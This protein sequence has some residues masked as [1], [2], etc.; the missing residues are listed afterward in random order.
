MK[1]LHV[2]LV[3]ILTG[4]LAFANS[5]RADEEKSLKPEVEQL[6]QSV[7]EK[8]EAAA[9]KLGLT[10]EQ[11]TKIRQIRD[12]H[13]EQIKSLRAERRKLLQEELA[14]L[15]SILKPEQKEKIKSLAEDRMEQAE[16]NGSAKGLPRFRALR[17]TL[18]ERAICDSEKLGLST[19]QRKQIV[20]TLAQH[21]EQH[22]SLKEKCREASEAEFKEIAAVLTPEQKQKARE[23]VEERIVKAAAAKSIADRLNA[24]ADNL[25]LTSDQRAQIA[26]IH[27]PFAAKYRELRANRREMLHDE[28]KAIGAV[29]TPEQREKVK[30]FC[31]DRVVVIQVSGSGRDAAEAAKALRETISERLEVAADKLE[32]TPE[33][34]K[35]IRALQTSWA[36]KF[37]EQRQQR[38]ALRRDELKAISAA[39]TPEQRE[40]VRNFV[41]DQPEA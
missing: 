37:K 19:D 24:I 9:D 15:G 30:D 29:L 33:Q 14:A 11:R 8:L 6:K 36:D 10:S 3:G 32:L 38:I 7:S 39:L 12:S 22:A 17:S 18:A 34:R 23:F 13:A 2:L 21:A 28:L 20:E 16:Q 27:A 26:E 25:K 40:K 35:E 4:L 41:E 31:E 1:S 5:V